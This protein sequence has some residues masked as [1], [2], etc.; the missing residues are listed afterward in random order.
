[1]DGRDAALVEDEAQVERVRDAGP[2]AGR[3]R[4]WH[5]GR[6]ADLLEPLARHR[7][8]RDVGQHP[9]ALADEHARRL[10]RCG[11]VR[12]E[13]L[14]VADDLE[15][16]ER[17]DAGLAGQ[18]AGADRVLGGV[19]AGGV[20]QDREAVERQVVEQVLLARVGDVHAPDRDRNDLGP[21]RLDHA[22]RLGERSVLAGA[23]DQPRA[24][25]ASGEDEGIAHPPPTKLMTSTA[26]PACSTVA[27]YSARGTTARFTSTAMRRGPSPSA[28]TR[29]A[30]VAPAVRSR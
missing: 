17:P 26:S 8:V 16:D 20:R 6:A 24:V 22:P 11:D 13:R 30:T 5:D 1:G 9:E 27:P 2:R 3:R 7:V 15:L 18:A 19:A 28:A 14:L 29:S 4:E 12:E 23:D 25:L 21:R 10:D